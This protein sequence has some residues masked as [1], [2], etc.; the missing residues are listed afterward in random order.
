MS[1]IPN[2]RMEFFSPIMRISLTDGT[3]T[4]GYTGLEKLEHFDAPF[5]TTEADKM[6]DAYER[7]LDRRHGE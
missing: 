6:T 7:M 5:V 2:E 3:E 1:D 4:E